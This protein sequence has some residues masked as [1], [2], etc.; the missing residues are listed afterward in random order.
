[1]TF[2]FL[3][4]QN[5]KYII[6]I[7]LLYAMTL[8]SL[9]SD[10]SECIKSW[11]YFHHGELFLIAFRKIHSQSLIWYFVE[12]SCTGSLYRDI[13]IPFSRQFLEN[14]NNFAIMSQWQ[15][16]IYFKVA[17]LIQCYILR[18]NFRCFLN[19]TKCSLI[20]NNIRNILS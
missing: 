6:V 16:A 3:P 2:I 15:L 4:L 9:A 17:K 8:L 12:D 20:S 10:A 19:F 1:M 18:Y 13:V 7:N 5:Y 14:S 11:N